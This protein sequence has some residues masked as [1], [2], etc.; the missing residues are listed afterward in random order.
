MDIILCRNVLM[1]FSKDAAQAT[2]EKVQRSLVPD[3]RLIV[4]AIET[5]LVS[6]QHLVPEVCNGITTYRKSDIVQPGP[7]PAPPLISGAFSIPDVFRPV[8]VSSFGTE[9]QGAPARKPE[10]E[11]K[12]LH[13]PALVQK[14]HWTIP[15]LPEK[16][17]YSIAAALFESGDYSGAEKILISYTAV[18][19]H[20]QRAMALMAQVLAN[21]GDLAGARGWCVKAIAQDK[22][23]PFFHH[24]LATIRQEEG[25]MDDAIGELRRALYADPTYIPA[26][27]TLANIKRRQ[28]LLDESDVHFR[29]VRTLLHSYQPGEVVGGAGGMSAAGLERI[30]FSF[31]GKEGI[32]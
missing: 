29:N 28:G 24:L 1:Y 6:S 31:I 22:M 17:P 4:S 2:V 7:V 30:I 10:E 23:N 27:F 11:L 3:G 5:S 8:A 19:P 26:H 9:H 12:V 14:E 15:S 13:T 21:R 16:D 20:D 25:A 18:R 32:A